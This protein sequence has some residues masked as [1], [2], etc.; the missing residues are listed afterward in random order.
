VLLSV[1]ALGVSYISFGMIWSFVQLMGVA[2]HLTTL[3]VT[4]G[5]SA[6]AVTGI[7]GALG[8]A[9]LPAK[10]N[11]VAVLS[12]ALATLLGSIYLM[13][14]GPGYAWFLVGCGV[15]GFY[16]TFYC[17]IHVSLIAQAD[18]TG[19][20]IV[21]CGIAPSLGA[22]IGS[23]FGGRLINGADYLPTAQVGA[24]MAVLGLALTAVTVL[25]KMASPIGALSISTPKQ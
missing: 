16:W 18:I 9:V 13:Y 22:V 4:N 12:L 3:E 23:F 1:A 20:A 7:I 25:K 2:R 5:S 19:R 15:F 8:A 11:R 17:T 24:V 10:A 14:L 21:F 6:Y